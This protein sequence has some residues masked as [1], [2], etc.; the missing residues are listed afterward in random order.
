MQRDASGQ[1][2]LVRNELRTRDD[3]PVGSIPSQSRRSPNTSMTAPVSDLARSPMKPSHHE[4]RIERLVAR[5]HE[6]QR[7]CRTASMSSATSV[8]EMLSLTMRSLVA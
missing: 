4:G 5:S 7:T 3:L 2:S 6:Y 1:H 8:L